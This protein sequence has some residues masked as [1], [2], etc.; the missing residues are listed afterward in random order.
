MQN[1]HEINSFLKEFRLSLP[2]IKKMLLLIVCESY[3]YTHI[4]KENGN[5]R[6]F[7]NLTPAALQKF[8]MP[9]NNIFF[10]T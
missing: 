1:H 9:A 3:K 8:L 10:S 6:V 7:A 5:T 2:W 4:K